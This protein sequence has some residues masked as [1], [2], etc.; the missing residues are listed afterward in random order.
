MV[1]PHET[2]KSVESTAVDEI[3]A[4]LERVPDIQ[5]IGVRYE[6]QLASGHRL[7]ARID[8]GHD[9]VR[10][11]LLTEIKPNGAPRFARSAVYQL[12]SCI[13]HLHR[14]EHQDDTRQFIPMLV[15]PYLSAESRSICLDH[16][17]AYLDLYGN[18]HLAFGTVYIERSVAGRP[19]SETRA[20]R[21]LF[22]PR[23][24]AILRVLLRDPARAWRVT[25]LAEAA[26]ASLGHVSN[27]RK[28]LLEREWVEIRKDGLVLIQ[29]DALLK[30][31]RENYRQPAGHH[32]SGYT[33]LHGDQLRDRLSGSLNPGPQPP[34]AI[35]AS[36][37]AAQ[38]IAPYVRDGTH[39]FYADE[40]GARI[41]QEALQLT[42]AERGANV[43]LRIPNDETLFEDAVEP[44]P[45]IFCANPVV[46][47]LDLWNGNDR[48][49][50]AA[51]HLAATCFPWL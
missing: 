35:C 12:E 28:A 29:P 20:Q 43:I 38:W 45:S 37:S 11:A 19:K 41:L 51:D 44:A 32:I 6:E 36:H 1:K 4:L 27:V 33:V 50:E 13:A 18:A 10:Y 31:W 8:F 23:A 2:E 47:C 25:D 24:G 9:E 42:H 3:R 30:S 49:R 34:R 22:T 5:I 39:S 15:S 17:V 16:N 26:N 46:T 40:P 48:D 21:S 7:D 14:S